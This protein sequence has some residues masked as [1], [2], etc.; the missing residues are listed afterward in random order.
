MLAVAIIYLSFLVTV[1]IYIVYRQVVAFMTHRVKRL[2]KRRRRILSYVER[3]VRHGCFKVP[4][5]AK[6]WRQLSDVAQ[7]IGEKLEMTLSVEE[8][9]S[10]CRTDQERLVLS[11]SGIA[12]H[13]GRTSD[14]AGPSY[15]ELGWQSVIGGVGDVAYHATT[16][17]DVA[18]SI[19]QYGIVPTVYDGGKKPRAHVC[20][21][22]L[23][24]Q[25][26]KKRPIVIEVKLEGIQYWKEP[27]R[28]LFIADSIP[29]S[30][31]GWTPA[32]NIAYSTRSRTPTK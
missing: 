22:H 23:P 25:S 7:T 14:V 8:L 28:D 4:V 20:L 5:D 30:A 17:E 31:I 9:I 27:G 6:G 32:D 10:H 24:P 12:S 2:A 29:A 11:G 26:N 19:A 18:D 15:S 16:S 3:I 13:H 1:V 21:H